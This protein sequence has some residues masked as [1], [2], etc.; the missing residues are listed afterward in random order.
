MPRL[1]ELQKY[2]P[3][4]QVNLQQTDSAGEESL[5]EDE[6]SNRSGSNVVDEKLRLL[7]QNSAARFSNWRARAAQLNP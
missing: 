2:A 4:M 1:S 7:L 5:I 3:A 6:R